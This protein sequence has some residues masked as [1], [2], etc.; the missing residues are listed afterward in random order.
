MEFQPLGNQFLFQSPLYHVHLSLLFYFFG[1]TG[2]VNVR[3]LRYNDHYSW[4][5]VTTCVHNLFGG[6]RWVDQYGELLITN[7]TS[8][9]QCKL[10]FVKASYWSSNRHEVV[11]TVT[12]RSGRIVHHL[13]GN[14]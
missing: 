10:N 5:K 6:Q 12:D 13:F 2:S 3:L 7:R 1:A 8:G 4:N 14:C 11:G 9:V